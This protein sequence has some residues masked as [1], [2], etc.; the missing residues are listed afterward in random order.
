MTQRELTPSERAILR[1]AVKRLRQQ[2]QRER[3]RQSIGPAFATID[4]GLAL[5][6]FLDRTKH[7][8]DASVIAL[9]TVLIEAGNSEQAM[10]AL[11]DVMVQNA[12]AKADA[13]SVETFAAGTV[14]DATSVL[15][16]MEAWR[17]A[18]NQ[19]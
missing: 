14:I 17:A 11:Q 3:R 13:V 5:I 2:Q 18:A 8:V 19:N 10:V 9:A 1:A 4:S 15:P 12:R 6:R 7:S 16:N